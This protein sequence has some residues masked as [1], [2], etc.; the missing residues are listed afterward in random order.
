MRVWGRN[1]S[2]DWVEVTTDTNGQNENI[3]LTALSQVL[4][5]NLFESPFYANYGVP[6]YPT[7]ITQVFPNYYVMQIQQQYA[8]F[9]ASLSI[10]PVKG[11]TDPQY[12]IQ[13]VA[14]SGAILNP[15]IAT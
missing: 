10:T 2:G 3:Y 14:K 5:L 4:K 1:S 15:E 12:N 6:Q 8:P 13:A 9:F 7:M 11:A